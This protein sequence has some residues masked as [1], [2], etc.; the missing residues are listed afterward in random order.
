MIPDETPSARDLAERIREHVERLCA[1]GDRHPGTA[2]NR[3]ATDYVASVMREMGL[4][5]EELPFDVPEWEYGD[6]S[7][8]VRDRRFKMHP[9]PFSASADVEGDLVVVTDAGDLVS[10][11]A[12]DRVL[13]LRGAIAEVQFTPRGYPFYQDAAH[14]AV[15]DALEA[16]RA[17]A[18]LAATGKN[19]SMTA[20]M[21]PFPLIEEPAFAL[22][23]AYI[24]AE[25]GAELAAHEGER[26]RVRIDSGT[27]PSTGLQPVGTLGARE[28]RRV[29]I[30]AHIDSKPETPGALDNASGVAVLLAAAGLL[31]GTALDLAVEF[32]LF[33]GEDHVLAPGELAYLNTHSLPDIELMIN[34]DGAG[35]PGSPSAYSHYNADGPLIGLLERLAADNPSVALGETW[36]ASDHM[37]FAMQGIPAIAITSEDFATASGVYSHTPLDTPDVLDY[38]L[39]A[40][41]ARFVAEVAVSAAGTSTRTS[42]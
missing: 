6:T 37:I 11:D 28:G 25:E 12:R 15:L 36:P 38:A 22:P 2:R 40:G 34:I 13:L 24:T 20:G 35:L 27:R 23:T 16:T 21:S 31:A 10:L 4:A 9:G 39:L 33:N 29:V 30:G 19:P 18:V 8:S 1:P 17:L 3:A 41:T 5:V 32:V 26:V 42:A 7:A 14:A